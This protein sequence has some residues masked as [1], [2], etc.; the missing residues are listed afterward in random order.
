MNAED[1][2]IHWWPTPPMFIVEAQDVNIWDLINAKPG[3]VIRVSDP[4]RNQLIA[5]SWE[6][7][8]PIEDEL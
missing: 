5:A 4:S 8:Y 7:L 3:D 1:A 2:L 6:K